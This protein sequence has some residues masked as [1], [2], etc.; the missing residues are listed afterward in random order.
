MRKNWTNLILHTTATISRR[1]QDILVSHAWGAIG[2]VLIIVFL[3]LFLVIISLPLYLVSQKTGLGGKKQY[4]IRRIITLSVLV[5]I[6]AIWLLTLIFVLCL[7]WYSNPSQT[8]FMSGRQVSNPILAPDYG[9]SGISGVKIDSAVAVPA[10]IKIKTTETGGL[11]VMGKGNPGTKIVLSIGRISE[12]ES[13]DGVSL[14]LTDVDSAGNW[15]IND[16]GRNARLTAGDY[17]LRT[18]AYSAQNNSVSGFSPAVALEVG[19]N[20]QSQMA[21]QADIYLNYL[22]IIFL[23]LGLFSLLLLI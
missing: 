20:F 21:G 7:P 1:K 22:V 4:K 2:D 8:F 10:V 3:E 16:S 19:Q 9:L 17:W 11:F 6:L 13:G 5:I 14:F 15:S 12:T 23:L 18:M